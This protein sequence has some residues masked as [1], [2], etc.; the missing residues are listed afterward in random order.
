MQLQPPGIM[1]EPLF[2]QQVHQSQSTRGQIAYYVRLRTHC[3]HD[4]LHAHRRTLYVV[5]FGGEESHRLPVRA[6]SGRLSP[7]WQ[8]KRKSKSS[9]RGRS[10]SKGAN[11]KVRFFS[12]VACTSGDGKGCKFHLQG[13]C[14]RET[15]ASIIVLNL[16]SF[17]RRTSLVVSV[18]SVVMLSLLS[19]SPE[20]T[21]LRHHEGAAPQLSRRKGGD[22]RL[23]EPGQ[24]VLNTSIVGVIR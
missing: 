16:A 13:K 15:S 20:E 3:A 14:N 17:G 4:A 18:T 8:G 10:S 21:P 2:Y 1:L 24:C 19:S 9:S 5:G 12:P 23:E 22:G 6:R 7:E 11:S